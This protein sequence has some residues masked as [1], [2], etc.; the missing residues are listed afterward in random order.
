MITSDPRFFENGWLDGEV[1]IY[2]GGH[3]VVVCDGQQHW[4]LDEMGRR[5]PEGPCKPWI[6]PFTQKLI[7]HEKGTR[8]PPKECQCVKHETKLFDNNGEWSVKVTPSFC[9]KC[10]HPLLKEKP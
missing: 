1:G 2:A 10:G 5:Y 4:A 8:V 7:P 3:H 9:G 6:E